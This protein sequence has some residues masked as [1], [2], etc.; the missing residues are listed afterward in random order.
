MNSVIA[1]S[2]EIEQCFQACSYVGNNVIRTSLNFLDAHV[3]Y[4]LGVETHYQRVLDAATKVEEFLIESQKG[5]E[6]T[7]ELYVQA[8]YSRKQGKNL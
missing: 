5:G 1:M 6:D 4:S 3:S 7:N 2:E 8:V